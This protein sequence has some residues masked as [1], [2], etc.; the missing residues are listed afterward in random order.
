MFGPCDRDT[1][2]LADAGKRIA[3]IMLM[4]SATNIG[5]VGLIYHR[6]PSAMATARGRLF[7]LFKTW[8]KKQN[9]PL[10]YLKISEVKAQLSILPTY[11]SI[12]VELEHVCLK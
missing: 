1:K 9:I 12:F 4:N 6:E 11:H 3:I 7:V 2:S 8:A 5:R 10:K